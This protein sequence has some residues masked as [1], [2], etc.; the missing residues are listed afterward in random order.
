MFTCVVLVSLSRY[1]AVFVAMG[2]ILVCLNQ[3]QADKTHA[4]DGDSCLDDWAPYILASL[5]SAF[6]SAFNSVLGEFLLNKDKKNPILAVCEVSFFNS[7]IPFCTIGTFVLV[8]QWWENDPSS[9]FYRGPRCVKD[10][11]CEGYG[12]YR[13]YLEAHTIQNQTC[14]HD[15]F[16][17][18]AVGGPPL[19]PWGMI[20]DQV[21]AAGH[22]TT[23]VM[24]A[25]GL[26]VS[27]MVDRIAKFYIVALQGAFFFALLDTFR[28]LATA[29][30]AV[31]VTDRPTPRL[32]P[33]QCAV[34]GLLLLLPPP[35]PPPPSGGR[36]GGRADT[37]RAW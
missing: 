22:G 2:G 32:S 33:P 28:R 23:F 30:V 24:V 37:S 12:T 25:L 15:Q 29:M 1:V 5:C 6:C 18:K 8:T 36:T 35:P 26:C 11:C 31:V 20:A 14:W 19:R 10:E 16:S 7:F 27:K 21:S 34:R 3:S 4:C 17:P 13:G 9:F